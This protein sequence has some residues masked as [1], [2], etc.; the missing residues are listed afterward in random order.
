MPTAFLEPV[1]PPPLESLPRK[2][3][4]VCEIEDLISKG[5]S[6]KRYELIDGEI[7]DKKPGKTAPHVLAA[8]LLQEWLIGIFGFMRVLKGDPV[9]IDQ[10]NEPEPDLS[11]LRAPL[12][13]LGRKPR[14]EDTLL[15]VEVAA[16]TLSFDLSTKS[17]LYG[18]AGI[19][20][21]WV[22]D[23][24][25]RR[26]IVHREPVGGKYTSVVVYREDEAVAPLAG[27]DSAFRVA[28]AFGG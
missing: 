17:E 14:P 4:T 11:V 26:M 13:E 1:A 16:S 19:A 22:L 12:P 6:F 20:D 21:Y 9:H 28:A 5:C 27:P 23:V 25:Q 18:R 24:N 15:V 7:I 10:C 3:W 2:K 8:M